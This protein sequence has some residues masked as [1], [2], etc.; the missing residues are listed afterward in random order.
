MTPS[1]MA[2][3]AL[4]PG[5]TRLG[6]AQIVLPAAL[7]AMGVLLLRAAT[8]HRA[9]VWIVSLGAAGLLTTASKVAFIGWGLGSAALD[10]TGISGHAMF[11]AAIYPVLAATLAAGRSPPLRQ[12]AVALGVAIALAVGVSR[13]MVGAHSL[14]EVLL[15]LLVGGAA[16]GLA[17]TVP[18][19]ATPATRRRSGPWLAAGLALWLALMPLQA[20]P[21]NTHA[22]VTRLSLFL[23]GHSQPFTRAAMHRRAAALRRLQGGA[24]SRLRLGGGHDFLSLETRPGAR[25]EPGLPIAR[26]EAALRFA[27][28]GGARAGVLR[29]ADARRAGPGP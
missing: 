21:S 4:W 20:P 17:L 15:G 5:L 19:A 9:A 7:A 24:G 3:L 29:H 27:N 8:R 22:V 12:G 13:V 10:Y 23:A 2:G 26:P 6:E 14:S 18:A 28:V 1:H 25:A 11:A 16:S